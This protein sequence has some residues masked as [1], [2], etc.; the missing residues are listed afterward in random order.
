MRSV[1]DVVSCSDIACLGVTAAEP[2]TRRSTVAAGCQEAGQQHYRRTC[3]DTFPS[4]PQG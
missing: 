3:L 4:S 1:G 2:R